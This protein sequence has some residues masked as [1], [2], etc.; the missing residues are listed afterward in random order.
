LIL[1]KEV[2]LSF[3][4]YGQKTDWL[5]KHLK[6][7]ESIKE[8]TTK[9][10]L[11]IILG[12]LGLLIG[13][14][15]SDLIPV[16]LPSIIQQ[17]P[18]AVLLKMLTLALILFFLSLALSWVIYLQLKT[19]FKPKFGVVWDKS[20]EPYC[21]ACEK[22]LTK[23]TLQNHDKI[24]AKGLRCAKCGVHFTLITDEGEKISLIEAKKLL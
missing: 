8:S 2:T 6:I 18:K 20:K 22:P 17:L 24:I 1:L 16:I 11:S 23:Y 14:I 19:K 9:Y 15:Y 12:V 10:L 3:L 7:T 4:D 21:P 13:S 5:G